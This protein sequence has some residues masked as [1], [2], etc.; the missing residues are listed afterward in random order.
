MCVC[1]CRGLRHLLCKHAYSCFQR[2]TL[3]ILHTSAS[4]PSLSNTHTQ[5]HAQKCL[6]THTQVQHRTPFLQFSDPGERRTN[7]LMDSLGLRDA[8]EF[9]PSSLFPFPL[10]PFYLSLS[11]LVTSIKGPLIPRI[12]RSQH[13][14][15]SSQARLTLTKAR[16]H[17]DG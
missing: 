14:N 5:V 4:T 16:A 3:S 6:H 9:L 13:P 8:F 15:A 1:V 7:T 2:Q 10:F 11:L 17:V 12:H